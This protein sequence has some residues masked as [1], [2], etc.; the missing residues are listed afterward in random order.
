[1]QFIV[2]VVAIFSFLISSEARARDAQPFLNA[3]SGPRRTPVTVESG[4]SYGDC[5]H[6]VIAA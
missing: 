5:G 3:K 1:M 6:L 2:I 4:H